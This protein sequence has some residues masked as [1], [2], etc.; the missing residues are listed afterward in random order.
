MNRNCCKG[1]PGECLRR[2]LLSF[3]KGSN[4]HF[5]LISLSKLILWIL[6]RTSSLRLF[7]ESPNM[8][9]LRDRQIT[10]IL[11][12][13]SNTGT[14]SYLVVVTQ[15]HDI[16]ILSMKIMLQFPNHVYSQYLGPIL[17]YLTVN[18]NYK[19]KPSCASDKNSLFSHFTITI[20][21]L[22]ITHALLRAH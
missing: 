5:P 11:I 16:Y 13:F 7:F 12:F 4:F 19:Q 15:L 9:M 20:F 6:K 14:L 3:R 18:N 17:L 2:L 21:N 10:A 22:M 8:I 1:V